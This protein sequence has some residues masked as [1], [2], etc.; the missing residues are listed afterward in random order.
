VTRRLAVFDLDGTLTR[1]D[2]FVAFACGLLARHPWRCLR[3]PLLVLPALAFALR[4]ID[5]GGLKGAVLH[6]LFSGLPAP[7]VQ[8]WARQFARSCVP[9]RM[10]PQALAAFRA[11]VAAGDHTVLMSASPDLYVP[12]IASSL[13]ASECICTTVRWNGDHLDGR[14]SG[15]NCRGQEKA[16]I[17]E[18][19]RAQHAGLSIV[20]YGNSGADV[21]HLMRCD[22]AV[23]VNAQPRIRARLAQL[24]I[25]C[26]QWR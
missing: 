25:R 2:T 15:P 24:G 12:L 13:A 11:H 7:A 16:R 18:R 26:V 20:G 4:L 5:R 19:L 21:A 22:E 6:L 8:D 1:S 14:R 3:V 23:Y 9:G 17:L 10:F